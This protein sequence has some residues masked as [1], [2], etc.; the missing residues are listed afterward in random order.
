MFVRREAFE[1]LAGFAT[2]P[3]FED[4]EFSRRL[5]RAGRIRILPAPV[6]VSGRRFMARPIRSAVLMTVLPILYRLGVPP[7]TLARLYGQVR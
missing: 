4:L 3:L 5:R 2:V 6:R 1:A 7:A